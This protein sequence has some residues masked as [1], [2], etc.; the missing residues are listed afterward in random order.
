MWSNQR[1]QS[2]QM[3]LCLFRKFRT[4]H[5]TASNSSYTYK[6]YIPEY[7]KR[8]RQLPESDLMGL[9][10]K[11]ELSVIVSSWPASLQCCH[12]RPCSF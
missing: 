9:L 3:T 10:E 4:F 5:Y 2:K 11:Y 1:L 8:E 7:R 6:M 12:M